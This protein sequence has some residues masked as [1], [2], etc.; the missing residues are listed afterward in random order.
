MTPNCTQLNMDT[1]ICYVYFTTTKEKSS[2][3]ILSLWDSS[4]VT[5]MRNR[6]DISQNQTKRPSWVGGGG[7][8]LMAQT[9]HQG[10]IIDWGDQ[11]S[12][13][14]AQETYRTAVPIVTKAIDS[15]Q[16]QG[17]PGKIRVKTKD[18]GTVG[19][20]KRGP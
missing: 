6:R 20:P 5:G 18:A 2:I 3:N 12:E 4:W 1:T 9:N 11:E 15:L 19:G 8:G 13:E 17:P 7:H 10:I 16:C 14:I